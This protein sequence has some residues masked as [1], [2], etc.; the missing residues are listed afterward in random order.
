M[1]HVA[2]PFGLSLPTAGQ[3][4]A[5]PSRRAAGVRGQETGSLLAQVPAAARARMSQRALRLLHAAW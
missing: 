4:K 2:T 3:R 5:A 1:Q